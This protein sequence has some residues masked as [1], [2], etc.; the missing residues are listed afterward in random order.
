MLAFIWNISLH[1]CNKSKF[2]C[3]YCRTLN[4]QTF[5]NISKILARDSKSTTYKFA[6]LRGTIDLINDNS[7]YIEIKNDR[8]HFPL[9]L[10]I[11]KWLL[12]YYPLVD[13]PQINGTS[14][15]A[16]NSKL[17][18]LT[19]YYQTRGGFSA[20][21]ND[22]KNK[23]L[24]HQLHHLFLLLVK[25]IARTICTMPMRYIGKSVAIQDYSIYQ[26]EPGTRRKV[27]PEID[28]GYL[29]ERFGTFSIPMEYYEAFQILGSFISGQDAILFKWAEFSV[30]ASGKMLSMNQ[31][32][33]EVL[34]SPVTG[35]D[36]LASK[37]L[38]K[39]ILKKDGKV[40]CVWTGKLVNSYDIDHII[41]FT[42]WKNNDLWNLLPVTSA[43]N[44]KK[45]DKIPSI[46][47]IDNQRELI[48]HY[49]QILH[50]AEQHRFQKEIQLA[51]LGYT[52]AADWHATAIEQLKN[53]CGYLI[54]VRGFESWQGVSAG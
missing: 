24:P 36:L 25:I 1:T 23:G 16:F 27:S 14:S 2:Y 33:D 53:T 6:L 26:Y 22:L 13:T 40:Y 50:D 8:A 12:Y 37:K 42:V 51:L 31:V 47:L 43:I 35:R 4:Q 10:L 39:E 32:L 15:L 46:E 41:P 34:Q 30:R 45:S 21:Y 44:N 20:F 17:K 11:E 29:V 9:G 5:T 7:P 3:R 18:E 28:A 49:W 52:P 48:A 19:V 54:N 38:Y